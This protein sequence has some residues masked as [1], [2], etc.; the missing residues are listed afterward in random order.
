ML[1]CWSTH[2]VYTRARE[3]DVADL[4]R[5]ADREQEG[6]EAGGAA[7]GRNN[8]DAMAIVASSPPADHD[9]LIS[10]VEHS[11]S[12]REKLVDVLLT[13]LKLGEGNDALEGEGAMMI[14]GASS[15]S[16]GVHTRP[17]AYLHR[18]LQKEAFSMI[19][20]LR[21]LFPQV[22]MRRRRRMMCCNVM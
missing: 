14:E 2:D 5:L 19:G 12:L 7:A 3:I 6:D 20:S 1:V 11:L 21:T 8:D 15:S 13:W 17:G 4:A 16:S 22:M 10:K 18:S 9:E